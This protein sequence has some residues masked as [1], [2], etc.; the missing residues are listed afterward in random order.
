MYTSTSLCIFNFISIGSAVVEIIEFQ[1]TC[2]I[3]EKRA[4][5]ESV[6]Y[7]KT[8]SMLLTA[9]AGRNYRKTLDIF[10]MN[11]SNTLCGRNQILPTK[12]KDVIGDIKKLETEAGDIA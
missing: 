5:R 8:P 3:H 7:A 6:H 12:W 1:F 9:Y 10:I 11:R 2:N 4:S